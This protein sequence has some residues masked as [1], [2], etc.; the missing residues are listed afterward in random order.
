[1]KIKWKYYLFLFL[2]W[3]FIN[4]LQAQEVVATSGGS[5][6][7]SG[8]KVT[9]TIGEPV[10]ET[11]SST[12]IILTQG[13]NQGGLITTMIKKPEIPGLILNV[14]PNPSS[15]LIKISSGETDVSGMRYLLVDM[16][17]KVILEKNMSGNESDISLSTLPPSIYFLKVYQNKK[18]IGTYKIVKK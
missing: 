12:N 3:I 16:N 9:W 8:A 5:G 17:G 2:P 13:F 10:T 18:E 14:Y 7:T 4:I 11:I 15:D 1:M 6:T